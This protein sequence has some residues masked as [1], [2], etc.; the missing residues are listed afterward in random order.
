MNYKNMADMRI[1]ETSATITS[2]SLG[3]NNDGYGLWNNV[4]YVQRCVSE[5]HGVGK[6]TVQNSIGFGLECISKMV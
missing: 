6:V 4:Q 2:L 1:C 3:I 5:V